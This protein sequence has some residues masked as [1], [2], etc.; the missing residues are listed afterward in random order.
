MQESV[1]HAIAL[2]LTVIL[3]MLAIRFAFVSTSAAATPANTMD[4]K[5]I[6]AGEE[7]QNDEIMRYDSHTISGAQL[8]K[9]IESLY[10]KKIRISVEDLNGNELVFGYE[11]K[12]LTRRTDDSV[13]SAVER[14]RDEISSGALYQGSVQYNE[15]TMEITGLRFTRQEEEYE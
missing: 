9:V 13:G 1:T 14:A 8:I 12:R 4:K 5:T 7:L 2:A 10:P 3:A 6:L 11:D 15:K